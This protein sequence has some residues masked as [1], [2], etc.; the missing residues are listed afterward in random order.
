[1]GKLWREQNIVA[2]VWE[3]YIF[4][5]YLENQENKKEL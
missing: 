5:I 4:S 3:L 2:V 1:M